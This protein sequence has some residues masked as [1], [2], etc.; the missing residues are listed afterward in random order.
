MVKLYTGE[1]SPNDQRYVD[2]TAH[3]FQSLGQGFWTHLGILKN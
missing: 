3:E 1:N 2:P